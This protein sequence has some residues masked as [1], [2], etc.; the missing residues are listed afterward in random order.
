MV[1]PLVPAVVSST[2]CPHTVSSSAD[3]LPDPWSPP[4]G[5]AWPRRLVGPAARAH[6]SAAARCSRRL[7]PA[8]GDVSS[9]R[10]HSPPPY[11]PTAAADGADG[12][13]GATASYAVRGVGA[14]S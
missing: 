8:R 13:D 9:H 11:S 6:L 14:V 7:P 2:R 10:C 3:L 4:S 12:L 5:P 1:G